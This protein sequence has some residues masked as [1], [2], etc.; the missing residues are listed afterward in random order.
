VVFLFDDIQHFEKK[1]NYAIFLCKA[2]FNS[3]IGKLE[4]KIYLKNGGT[5]EFYV[6]ALPKYKPLC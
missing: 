5:A 3:R 6:K 2:Q 1:Q 4:I